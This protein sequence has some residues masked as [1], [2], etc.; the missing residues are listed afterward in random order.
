[1]PR[2]LQSWI[3]QRIASL[4][5]G[6]RDVLAGAAVLGWGLDLDV[7]AAVLDRSSA[8]VLDAKPTG[9]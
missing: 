6:P 5:Q 8:A 1:M 3:D 9:S 2:S 4:D 7:L